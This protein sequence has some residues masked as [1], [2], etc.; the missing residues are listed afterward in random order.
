[1]SEGLRRLCIYFVRVTVIASASFLNIEFCHVRD[2][3]VLGVRG[4]MDATGRC[5]D[6]ETWCNSAV[7]LNWLLKHA[8]CVFGTC[9]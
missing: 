2:I 3:E 7:G 8:F 9:I 6:D 4:V 5:R 1:V